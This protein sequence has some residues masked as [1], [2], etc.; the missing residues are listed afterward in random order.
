M[1]VLEFIQRSFGGHVVEQGQS[2]NVK[3]WKRSLGYQNRDFALRFLPN[4]A[5]H[6]RLKRH[7][8]EMMIHHHRQRLSVPGVKAQATV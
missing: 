6:S 2:P 4:L 7:K 8:I 3:L 5:K 1:G